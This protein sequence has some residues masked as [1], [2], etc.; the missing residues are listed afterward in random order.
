ML[1]HL[2]L[3]LE[4]EQLNLNTRNRKT[5][6]LTLEVEQRH[7]IEVIINSVAEPPKLEGALEVNDL[8]TRGERLF[9]NEILGPESIA[10][11]KGNM[12]WLLQLNNGYFFSN[13]V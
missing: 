13:L 10:F 1:F 5:L 4:V 2:I 12:F 8:L 6:T 11:H 9:E 3:T 7:K